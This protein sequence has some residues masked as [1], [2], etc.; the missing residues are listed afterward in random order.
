MSRTSLRST[1]NLPPPFDRRVPRP[2]RGDGWNA[3]ADI[4]VFV[5]A[6]EAE[7]EAMDRKRTGVHRR[8][9]KPDLTLRRRL[10]GLIWTLTF[11]GLKWR[12]AGWLSG[13]P[14]TTLHSTFARWTRLGLWRRLGQD[15]ALDGRLACGDEVLPSAVVAD[16]RSLRS[17][18]PAHQRPKSGLFRRGL[19]RKTTGCASA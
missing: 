18:P 14:F 3:L 7:L 9:R 8:G 13:V 6:I 19:Q 2:S 17:T 12:V 1:A 4:E 11:G 15:L 16:S 10:I 5:Y